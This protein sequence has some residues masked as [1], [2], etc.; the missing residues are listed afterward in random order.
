MK[1]ID[2]DIEEITEILIKSN[3]LL[4][5]NKLDEAEEGYRNILEYLNDHPDANH[6]LGLLLTK[7]GK[8]KEAEEF[9]IKA[10]E[11]EH[12][13]P[14]YFRSL[15]LHY[16]KSK[17]F[18]KSLFYIDKYSN[19]DKDS[20]QPKYL[21]AM[22]YS[23]MKDFDK[24]EL[25]L[26]QCL[27]L[28]RDNPTLLHSYGVI[29]THLNRFS[30]SVNFFKK[31]ISLKGDH[32]EA[33]ANLGLAY[34]RLFQYQNAI[35]AVKKSIELGNDID[36]PHKIYG[37]IL[38]ELGKKE[39]CLLHLEKARD[40][41]PDDELIYN[42][43]GIAYGEFGEQKKAEECH[44]KGIELNPSNYKHFRNLSNSR[45]LKKE[46]PLIEQMED[47]YYK[48]N[49]DIESKIELGFALGFIHDQF[50]N[51]ELAFKIIDE[52]NKL[53]YKKVIAE[54][55]Y[56][57][58]QVLK[59]S[60]KIKKNFDIINASNLEIKENNEYS[61]I[62][63]VGMPRSGSTV[64][65]RMIGN[66]EKVDDL[67]EFHAMDTL[68]KEKIINSK[69][70]PDFISDLKHEDIES[71]KNKFINMALDFRPNLKHFFIDKMPYNF[72]YCGILFMMFPN[73]KIIHS[74]R[75]PY[76][77]C[78]SIYMLKLHG[79]HHYS[80]NLSSIVKYYKMHIE[81]MDY[82]KKIFPNKILTIGN[83]EIVKNPKISAEKLFNFCKIEY[84]EGFEKI[85]L[86]KNNIRTAS[87]VQAREKINKK[88]ISRWKNY[89]KD[90]NILI[91]EFKL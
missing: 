52:T 74:L 3:D 84:Q 7:K 40:L 68:I 46:D 62:F 76:D 48:K 53:N 47:I 82:W 18:D 20:L 50:N 17:D 36:I 1:N 60:K 5:A 75:N 90:L 25:I 66:C 22:V 43:L 72:L 29:L 69:S 81:I 88:S 41:N 59:E 70:F 71:M 87:N 30:E 51:F 24:S 67:Q 37:S 6:N 8:V 35:T 89:K 12:A 27:E 19:I 31:V 63:I 14:Q 73:A 38:K 83:E 34:A 2:I 32:W 77:N 49:L 39:E 61:P 13:I 26:R 56:D 44:R 45:R 57:I 16:L 78:L 91:N 33:Y 55:K 64:V 23:E 54:N 86:N 11:S 80:Y 42:A 21:K 58:D 15:S 9:L 79:G 10:T 65:S 28:N 4:T 85:E